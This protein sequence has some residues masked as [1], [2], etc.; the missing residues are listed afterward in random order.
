MTKACS[1]FFENCHLAL[2]HTPPT[3]VKICC[4]DQAGC[5]ETNEMCE[6]KNEQHVAREETQC[7]T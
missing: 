2:L 7:S 5:L 6:V 1:A 3:D 4:R